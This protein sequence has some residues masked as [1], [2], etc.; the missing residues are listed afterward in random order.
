VKGSIKFPPTST[1]AVNTRGFAALA[2]EIYLEIASHIPSVPIPTSQSIYSESYPDIRRS[3]HETLLSLT[4][5]SRSLRRFFWR[6]L[7]QRIEVRE[8]M[9]IGGKDGTLNGTRTRAAYLGKSAD[10]TGHKNYA[11]ELVRQLE[12]VTIRNPQLA[13]YVNYLDIF[14]VEYS[15]ETVLAELA[16]CLSLFPNL[17]TVQIDVDTSSRRRRSSLKVFEQTFKNC[18]YPQIRNVFVMFSS[19]SF[20]ACC[21]QTRRVG[22]T[23]SYSMS[24]ACLQFIQLN[25]PHLEVLESFGDVFWTPYACN[26]VVDNFPNLRTIQFWILPSVGDGNPSNINVLRK[27][28]HLQTIIMRTPPPIARPWPIYEDRAHTDKV[29]EDWIESAKCILIRIQLRDNLE[30]TVI[31]RDY[32]GYER[33]ISLK[34]KSLVDSF[35]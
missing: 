34:P 19:E 22:F 9:K 28:N 13:Q 4:Q 7:W 33:R 6:Y 18:S 21:P 35:A 14:I 32:D 29:K 26:L 20:I 3:R 31:M 23:H 10:A 8:G 1:H 25:C 17:H 30:K 2:D 12:I 11:I 16:R 24:R 15:I 27:L 5:T